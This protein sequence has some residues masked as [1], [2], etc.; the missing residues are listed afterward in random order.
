MINDGVLQHLRVGSGA[1]L[2]AKYLSRPRAENA[3]LVFSGAAAGIF[4]PCRRARSFRA[5]VLFALHGFVVR[6]DA[7][8]RRMLAERDLGTRRPLQHDSGFRQRGLDGFGIVGGFRK[9]D[10]EEILPRSPRGERRLLRL[11]GNNCVVEAE[12]PLVNL[13]TL[14]HDNETLH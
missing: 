5:L 13:A 3:S 10:P 2:G 4:P 1:G 14:S 6:S 8:Q 7:R 12:M 9:T 11:P